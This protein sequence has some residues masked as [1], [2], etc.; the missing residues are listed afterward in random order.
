MKTRQI[1]TL[2]HK[3]KMYRVIHDEGASLNQY[4]VVADYYEATESGMKHR[5]KQIE[6][7]ADIASAV[8]MLAQVARE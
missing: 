7:Y 8:E 4:R 6:R 1:A 2:L 3:G 5:H